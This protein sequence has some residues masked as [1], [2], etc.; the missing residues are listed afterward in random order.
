MLIAYFFNAYEKFT[1]KVNWSNNYSHEKLNNQSEAISS[2]I[3]KMP[4]LY[5][6]L[7]ERLTSTTTFCKKSNAYI[8]FHRFAFSYLS[9]SLQNIFYF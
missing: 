6:R 5:L 4:S 2:K 7:L 9:T 8:M 1:S 3:I